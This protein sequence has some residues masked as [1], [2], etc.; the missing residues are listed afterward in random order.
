[1]RPNVPPGSADSTLIEPRREVLHGPQP[2][3][4]PHRGAYLARRAARMQAQAVRAQIVYGLTVGWV[5]TLGGGF[6][7]CCVPSRL[8]PLWAA[9][10]LLGTLHLAAAVVVPQLLS[11]PQRLWARLAHWQGALVM[12]VLL[13]LIYL[14][15]I[16]PAGWLTRRQHRGFLRWT[17]A[18][19]PGTTA[20]EP[21]LEE[22]AA[23]PHHPRSA[24]HSLLWLALGVLGFFIR[25]GNYLLVPILIVLLIVGLALYFVQTSALAPLIYTLF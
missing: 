7:Y 13:T 14:L 11:V 18:P 16:W 20:W 12:K 1:M 3:R 25:R 8:D 10:T 5:L 22:P 2:G 6:W 4:P 9:V 23:A 17:V 24:S 21:V 19:P 15:L